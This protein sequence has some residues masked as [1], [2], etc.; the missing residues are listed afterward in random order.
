[1]LKLLAFYIHLKTTF[2]SIFKLKPLPSKFSNIK[3]EEISLSWAYVRE[4]VKL[5]AET[6]KSSKRYT[7]EMKEDLDYVKFFKIESTEEY[8]NEFIC[9]IDN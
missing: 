1:M 6:Y 7:E 5:I 8:N 4:Y 9:G 2:R 3:I